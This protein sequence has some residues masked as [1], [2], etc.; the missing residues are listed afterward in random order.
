MKIRLIA[1]PILALILSLNAHATTVPYKNFD[2]LVDESDNVVGGTVANMTSNKH[3]DG[4]IYTVVTLTDAFTITETGKTATNRPIKIRYKG[5]EVALPGKSGGDAGVEGLYVSGTP[6]LA[7]GENVIL[8]LSNNGI[9]DMPIYG[10]GQGLFHIDG[11]EGINDAKR[12]P[13]VALDGAHLV[14]KTPNGLVSRNKA[15]PNRKVGKGADA[16]LMNSDGG[17]DIVINNE[18]ANVA[19]LDKLSSYSAMHVSNFVSMIQERKAMKA[20]M[21]AKAVKRPAVL[22]TLPEVSGI[23][24]SAGMKAGNSRQTPLTTQGPVD[25][26]P[27]K[28]IS[29]PGRNDNGE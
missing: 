6:E 18:Q 20:G 12:L 9:A 21:V 22:F 17:E 26:K 19:T 2:S 14:L 15:M 3:K 8:F 11:A 27:V 10:W 7:V 1:I 28:P 23:Q 29:R 13:V 24:A 5:G 4:E 25:E 16:V